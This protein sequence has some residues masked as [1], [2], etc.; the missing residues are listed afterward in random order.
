MDN[1]NLENLRKIAKVFQPENIITNTEIDQVLKGIMEI[2]ATYKKGTESINQETKQ[3]VNNLLQQVIDYNNK[4]IAEITENFKNENQVAHDTRL[5]DLEELLSNVKTTMDDIEVMASNLKDGKDADEGRVIEEVLSKIQ[6]PEYKEQIE[7]T[8]ETII[9]KLNELDYSEDNKIDYARLKNVPVIKGKSIMGSPTVISNAVDL[10]GSTRA[11]GC[12]IVWDAT[13]GRY[14]HSASAG[15]GT[16]TSVSVTT[17]NGI[18]GTVANPTTT[19]AISLDVSGLDASK[20]GAG[21]VSNTEFG[22]LDGV[23]SAIQTQLNT[24]ISDIVQDTTPQLGG[25]LDVNGKTITSA[26]NGNIAVAPNGTGD[27]Y[28]NTNQLYV[29]TSS[30]HIGVGVTT[31][32][33]TLPSGFSAGK[34]IEVRGATTGQD[35][36]LFLRRS[37]ANVGLDLWSDSNGASFPT[38]LDNRYSGSDFVFRVN[39]SATPTERMRLTSTG[40]LGLGVTPTAVLHLKAGTA[41]ASTAPLKLTAGT[42]NTTPEAGTMEFDGTNFY[43]TI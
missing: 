14:T 41:T 23:T 3:V 15:S 36:G 13:R 22:Y 24:K 40:N 42:V 1:Q 5:K 25:N 6:L 9:D 26:S 43:L 21:T 4:S 19:P 29:D 39:G 16:V 30:G 20:I 32:G 34:A 11:N 35:P 10:D 28:V 12:S 33:A 17:A 37:D 2:L 18:S 8:G 31:P 7:I 27:F 38:Y